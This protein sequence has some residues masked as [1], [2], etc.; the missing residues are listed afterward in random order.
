MAIFESEAQIYAVMQA[1][2]ERLAANPTQIESFTH[3]NLV[4]R[5]LLA[6]PTAEILLDGRQP[7]LEVFYGSRPGRANVEV[8]LEADLLHN[9]W[10]SHQSMTEALF[11]G[12]IK[13]KGN[14]MKASKLIDLFRECERV[15]PDVIATLNLSETNST[16]RPAGLF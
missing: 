11:S 13:T 7:P 3:S 8:S 10:L 14:V 2:F 1:V 12:K 16:E 15:Y 9:I 6:N 5:I 4:I